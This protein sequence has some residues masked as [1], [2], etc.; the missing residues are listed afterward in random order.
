MENKHMMNASRFIVSRDVPL[1]FSLPEF[2]YDRK[3]IIEAD[4]SHLDYARTDEGRLVRE[5]D[6]A[7]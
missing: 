6:D 3:S 7:R 5:Q 2:K 1:P 4:S